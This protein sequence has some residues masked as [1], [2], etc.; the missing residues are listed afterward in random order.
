MTAT[1]TAADVLRITGTSY[2]QLD[3]WCRTGRLGSS[4]LSRRAQRAF[5]AD[6]LL[7]VEYVATFLADGF[8]VD[9]AFTI[10]ALLVA[11]PTQEVTLKSGL[12]HITLPG[13]T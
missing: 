1:Y 2:R 11:D 3:T 13:S 12:V 4:A 9:A 6:E 5:S 10:A 8:T 7:L